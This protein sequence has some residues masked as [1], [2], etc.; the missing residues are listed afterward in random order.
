MEPSLVVKRGVQRQLQ[1]VVERL[2]EQCF[3]QKSYRQVIGIAIEAKNLE[4]LRRT[5]LRASEDERK[6]PDESRRSEE[7]M[8]YV[9]DVCMNIVQERAF[10]N[11]V[12]EL[13]LSIGNGLLITTL[14]DPQT[15]PGS[16]ERDSGARLL[17]DSQ[18]CRVS[19]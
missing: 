4:V 2:F 16:F 18:V 7:L 8:E 13:G 5:I 11:E 17:L 6:H 12:S 19:Q 3:Q 10:R 9:L 15:H 14:P 1:A